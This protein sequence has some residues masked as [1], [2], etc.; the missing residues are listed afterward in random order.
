VIEDHITATEGVQA[1]QLD[2]LYQMERWGEDPELQLKL[3]NSRREMLDAFNFI[4]LLK[5]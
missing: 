5:V 2:S 3:Q 4:D 1:A